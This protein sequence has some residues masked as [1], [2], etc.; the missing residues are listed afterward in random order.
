MPLQLVDSIVVNVVVVV[1]VAVVVLL[2]L[3]LLLLLYLLS[4]LLCF[5]IVVDDVGRK[6]RCKISSNHHL[7]LKQSFVAVTFSYYLCPC[8]IVKSIFLSSRWWLP[9]LKRY[10]PLFPHNHSRLTTARGLQ[11][12]AVVVADVF[13]CYGQFG[14]DF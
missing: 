2:S 7:L 5:G 9:A 6:Q 13:C 4:L 1:V 10:R 8:L 3:L 11:V 12:A 14:C